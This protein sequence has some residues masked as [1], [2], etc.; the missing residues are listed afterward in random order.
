MVKSLVD[1]MAYADSGPRTSEQLV[2]TF[3]NR[4]PAEHKD[5]VGEKWESLNDQ[6][7]KILNN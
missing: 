3:Q 1:L 6:K 7:E 5:L 2:R 4:S